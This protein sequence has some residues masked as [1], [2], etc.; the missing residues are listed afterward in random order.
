[1][2]DETVVGEE[3]PQVGMPDEEDPEEIERFALVPVGG[4]PHAG[5]RV[6]DG[7]LIV[8]A[9]HLQPQSAVVGD[10]QQMVNHRES[11]R[12]PIVG[13]GQRFA[14]F[15]TARRRVAAP[16]IAAAEHAAA[17]SRGSCRCRVPLGAPITQVVQAA[18]IHEHLELQT[19]GVPK[20]S[21]ALQQVG[22][23]DGVT[24]FPCGVVQPL[25]PLAQMRFNGRGDGRIFVVE[26]HRVA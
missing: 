8:L 2:A 1:M 5:D 18:E 19:L 10:R 25:N 22:R 13:L 17:E 7:S 6:H 9:G 3:A 23:R 14:G 15:R 16:G 11:R 4:C 21:A 20:D 12:G 24:Q 26:C